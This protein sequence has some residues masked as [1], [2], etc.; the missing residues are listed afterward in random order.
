MKKLVLF[1]LILSLLVPS[2]AQASQVVDRKW[3][4]ENEYFGRGGLRLD[5][6]ITRAELATLIVR[7]M[8]FKSDEYKNVDLTFKDI[9]NY[10]GGWAAKDISIAAEE[11]IIRGVS[12]DRFNPSG[13]V[14]Y[15]EL[16]TV[17]MRA[18]GYRDGI[19]FSNYPDD[20]YNKAME[21]GLASLYISGDK[22]VSREIV[23][24]TIEN[25]LKTSLK[26]SEITLFEILN[27]ENNLK[28][29][30]VE[31]KEIKIANLVFNTLV[32]GTFKGQLVGRDDFTGYRVLLLSQNGN[33]Y[34]NMILDKKGE[35]SLT[36]F[37]IGF[38]GK[39]NG[40]KYE[41]YDSSGNL[42]LEDVLK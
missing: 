2:L 39:L 20:Y 42:A 10:Q 16:L 33:I 26:N 1:V 11:G 19:D 29:K 12:K 14:V 9:K 7:L 6:K 27:S 37:D 17:F 25:A 4:I 34:D 13:N 30:D 41:I 24:T 5:E 32:S 28:P 8:G 3:I 31:E 36:D 40:Y 38:L 22:E 35:F 15:N 21:I 18:L 23:L